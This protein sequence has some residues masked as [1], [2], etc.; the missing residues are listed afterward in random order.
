MV[1][2]GTNETAGAG[3]GIMVLN[4]TELRWIKEALQRQ[5]EREERLLIFLKGSRALAE[6]VALHNMRIRDQEAIVSGYRHLLHKVS[7]QIG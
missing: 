1:T 5:M 4:L 6:D 7:L 2:A 3:A